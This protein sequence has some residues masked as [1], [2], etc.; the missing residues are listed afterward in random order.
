MRYA[1]AVAP[2]QLSLE[3]DAEFPDEVP[4]RYYIAP[5]QESMVV[6]RERGKKMA[7]PMRWGLVPSWAKDE[8]IGNKLANARSETASELNSFRA[9]YRRRRCLIPMTGF[10]EWT[11]SISGYDLFGEPIKA[12]K[13]TP[14]QPYLFTVAD[15]KFF[16]VAGLYEVWRDELFTFTVLTTSANELVDKFLDRMPCI[17]RPSEYEEWLRPTERITDIQPLLRPYPAYAMAARPVNVAL[18][19]ARNEG[20]HLWSA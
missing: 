15:A 3:L 8:S 12:P 7:W 18:N 2:K 17:L 9:A 10:Y 4:A 1:M 20:A 5:T 14:R 13:G 11:E 16:C 6:I 19:N